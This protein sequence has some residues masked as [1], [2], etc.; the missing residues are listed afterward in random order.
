MYKKKVQ[1]TYCVDT[2]RGPIGPYQ[3]QSRHKFSSCRSIYSGKVQAC[4][5]KVSSSREHTV[6]AIMALVEANLFLYS[7]MYSST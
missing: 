7:S 3:T 5:L 2:P 1:H 6:D 4:E